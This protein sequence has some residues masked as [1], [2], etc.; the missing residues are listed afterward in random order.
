MQPGIE[1][2]EAASILTN[3]GI[4]IVIDKCLK[5]ENDSNFKKNDL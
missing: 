1:N 5:I 3:P 2:H 4:D